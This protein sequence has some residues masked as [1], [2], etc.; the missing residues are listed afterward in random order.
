MQH[1]VLASM[2]LIDNK[3][4]L[5]AMGRRLLKNTADQAGNGLFQLFCLLKIEAALQFRQHQETTTRLSP[6]RLAGSIS[7]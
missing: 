1:S 5:P 4:P 7:R 3:L 2:G 6:V